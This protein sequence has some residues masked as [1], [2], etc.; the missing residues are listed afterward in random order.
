MAEQG[1]KVQEVHWF[2]AVVLG[3]LASVIVRLTAGTGVLASYGW[4]GLAGAL[5]LGMRLLPDRA[6]WPLRIL[7]YGFGFLG[8]AIFAGLMLLAPGATAYTFSKT[9]VETF[10]RW[11]QML[12][13]LGWLVAL[14]ATS[15][16]L[17]S[18]ALRRQAGDRLGAWAPALL[19]LVS[20]ARQMPAWGAVALYINFVLIAMGCF[21][22]LA[23]MLHDPAQPLFLPGA[24]SE[25]SHG[26]LADY[27]LWHLLDA[28]PGV[29]VPETIRWSAPL[30]YERPGAGWL[31]LLFKV[32]VIMP[33]VSGIG[34]YLKDEGTTPE[35]SKGA[36]P[37]HRG[38][39]GPSG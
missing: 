6:G 32:M 34:R 2:G 31:L 36:P 27:L 22:G 33:V 38:P 19:R 24:R 35:K 20:F 13:L 7:C 8:G 16:L 21:A 25:V 9:V 5:I 12:T 26:T 3:L 18:R 14:A 23:F 30:T 11:L 17:H 37:R 15:V 28:I 10:P 1:P 39:V 4:I 29:K